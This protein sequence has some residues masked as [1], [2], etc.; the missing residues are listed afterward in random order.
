M[1]RTIYCGESCGSQRLQSKDGTKTKKYHVN[2]LKKYTAGEPGV[3]AVHA[4]YR[5]D[6]II[7]VARVIYQDTD[8]E[9]L[10]VPDFSDQ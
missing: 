1:Q 4:S 6:A 2:M 9:L 5:D 7:A 10:E 3:D 8:P